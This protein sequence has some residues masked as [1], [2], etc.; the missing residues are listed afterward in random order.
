MGKDEIDYQAITGASIEKRA[1][2]FSSPPK[3][4][5]SPLGHGA[6]DPRSGLQSTVGR[7]EGP[8][9]KMIKLMGSL[10]MK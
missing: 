3:I 5:S 2:R 6:L 7:E 4:R 1:S 10:D 9:N 8:E